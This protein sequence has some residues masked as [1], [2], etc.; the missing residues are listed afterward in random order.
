MR[1]RKEGFPMTPYDVLMAALHGRR[2]IRKGDLG[3]AERWLKVAERAAAIHQ[4]LSA[5]DRSTEEPR[6]RRNP[7]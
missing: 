4:R 6:P 2:A 3:A 7:L 5:I 1:M